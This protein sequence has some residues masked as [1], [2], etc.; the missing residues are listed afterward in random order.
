[1]RT[2]DA[3]HIAVVVLRYEADLSVPRI[4]EHL[5][6]AE[7]TVKSRLNAARRQM[8]IAIAGSGADA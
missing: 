5:G 8:R 2:L 7:G 6:I 3:D 1:M 4:A